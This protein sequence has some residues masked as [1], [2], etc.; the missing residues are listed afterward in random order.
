MQ[1]RAPSRY[2]LRWLEEHAYAR[3]RPFTLA[4]F[5]VPWAADHAPLVYVETDRMREWNARYTRAE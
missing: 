5:D 3:G 2:P 1:T 4:P